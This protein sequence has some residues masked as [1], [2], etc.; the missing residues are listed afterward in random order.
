[1]WLMVQFDLPVETA[2]QRRVY[3][4]F[5]KRLLGFGFAMLQKS[6]Y[7]RFEES[8]GRADGTVREVR[9]IL[10]EEGRVTVLRLSERT[11]GASKFFADGSEV[12]GP[13][14]PEAILVS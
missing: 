2:E 5:R 3:T 8:D 7:L 1:M 10:P 14:P 11:L 13:R 9:N 6:V 12:E 4:R